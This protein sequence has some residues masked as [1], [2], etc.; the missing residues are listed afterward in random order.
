[1]IAAAHTT[2]VTMVA[3]IPRANALS[4]SSN[5]SSKSLDN[6]TSAPHLIRNASPLATSLLQED[7]MEFHR[8]NRFAALVGC[9][10]LAAF[11]TFAQT[12]TK[13]AGGPTDPQIA[14]IVVAANQVDID[15]AKVAKGQSKNADVKEFADTMIRDHE[16]ANKQAKEL[17]TKLHVKPEENA[18]SK[19]LKEGGKKNIAALKKLKGTAFDKAYIEH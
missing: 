17:V 12:A 18:T 8:T 9:T 13:G 1:M 5:L 19:S 15:A 10:A 4:I 2:A 14:A 16:G 6:Q 11:Q 7:A 3:N